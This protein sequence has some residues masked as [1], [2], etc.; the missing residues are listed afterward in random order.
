MKSYLAFGFGI[1]TGIAVV[2]LSQSTYSSDKRYPVDPTVTYESP[3]YATFHCPTRWTL[4][5]EDWKCHSVPFG[6]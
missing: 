5:A 1:V 3:G 4:Q 6:W 2:V